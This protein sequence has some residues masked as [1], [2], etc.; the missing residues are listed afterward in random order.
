MFKLQ[1][2]IRY[3]PGLRRLIWKII[4]LF[5]QCSSGAFGDQFKRGDHVCVHGKCLDKLP[6]QL[7]KYGNN[8]YVFYSVKLQKHAMFNTEMSYEDLKK[9]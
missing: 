9:S 5:T 2:F 3:L 6:S 4:F 8:L 1:S 7:A